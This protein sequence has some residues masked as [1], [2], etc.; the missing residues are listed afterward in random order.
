MKL[1]TS[2]PKKH[3]LNKQHLINAKYWQFNWN[4]ILDSQ[5]QSQNYFTTDGQLASLYAYM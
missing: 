2:T 1:T 5:S 4:L 3:T